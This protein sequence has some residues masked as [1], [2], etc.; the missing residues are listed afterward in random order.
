MISGSSVIVLSVV[1][2]PR[3]GEPSSSV[4]RFVPPPSPPPLNKLDKIMIGK[5]ARVVVEGGGDHILH[6]NPRRARGAALFDRG[7]LELMRSPSL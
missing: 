6:S 4:F 5:G 1:R 3:E 7:K 2:F